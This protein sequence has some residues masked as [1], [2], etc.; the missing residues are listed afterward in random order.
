MQKP[1]KVAIQMLLPCQGGAVI[2]SARQPGAKMYI[3]DHNLSG[4]VA[5]E[6]RAKETVRIVFVTLGVVCVL[7]AAII[8]VVF[9]VN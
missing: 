6:Q 1:G 2:T 9:H 5:R 4:R 7:W 8:A 3:S